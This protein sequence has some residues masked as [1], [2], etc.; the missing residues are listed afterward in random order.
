MSSREVEKEGSNFCENRAKTSQ[1]L[2]PFRD[3]TTR[4][5][6]DW[7]D[8]SK[9]PQENGTVFPCTHLPVN[10]SHSPPRFTRGRVFS[11]RLLPEQHVFGKQQSP[12]REALAGGLPAFSPA[13]SGSGRPAGAGTPRESS[14]DLRP[15]MEPRARVFP[16]P[17]W[18]SRCSVRARSRTG[19]CSPTEARIPGPRHLPPA[20]PLLPPSWPGPGRPLPARSAP[21][22]PGR[23]AR[24]RRG[25]GAGG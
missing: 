22:A 24:S 7:R 12:V 15:G 16:A 23:P 5:K 4:Q 17:T 1:T 6:H 9:P 11:W 3:V 14:T 2:A 13:G 19:P 8:P 18:R 10:P 20:A 21:A 25:A